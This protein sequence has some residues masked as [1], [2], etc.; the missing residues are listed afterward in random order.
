MLGGNLAEGMPRL[1][2][3]CGGFRGVDTDKTYGYFGAAFAYMNGVA[4]NDAAASV[5]GGKG[6][7]KEAAEK[8]DCDDANYQAAGLRNQLA[9]F[10]GRISSN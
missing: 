5:Q 6:R 3:A 10:L 2:L 1:T 8:R 7:G 4:V 9:L